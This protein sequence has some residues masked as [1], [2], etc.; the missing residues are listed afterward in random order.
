VAAA[1]PRDRT[2]D[3]LGA[4]LARAV[5]ARASRG[6]GTAGPSRAL[7]QRANDKFAVRFTRDALAKEADAV[8]ATLGEI[9]RAQ[10]QVKTQARA[11]L[12]VDH[13]AGVANLE[14]R[15]E[16]LAKLA[17]P[18]VSSA[19]NTR[20]LTAA[21]M[22]INEPKAPTAVFPWH[23]EPATVAAAACTALVPR[24]KEAI[25]A[26]DA[27]SE[28][29]DE[30]ASDIT[31]RLTALTAL[32]DG[33]EIA[34]K[35]SIIV[36]K[37]A[38]QSGVD[39]PPRKVSA[40]TAS[41]RFNTALG[42]AI[43]R[44][45]SSSFVLA[46]ELGAF[47]PSEQAYVE[48]KIKA[49]GQKKAAPP[50][51]AHP[52][53]HLDAAAETQAKDILAHVA[54]SLDTAAGLLKRVTA[55]AGDVHTTTTEHARHYLADPLVAAYEKGF[56][57]TGMDLPKLKAA[58]S[59]AAERAGFTLAF[60]KRAGN[61]EIFITSESAGKAVVGELYEEDERFVRAAASST[62]TTPG[63]V[64]LHIESGGEYVRD[65]SDLFVRRFVSR[66]LN[67]YDNPPTN[68]DTIKISVD[69]RERK[70]SGTKWAAVA[71][72]LPTA[73]ETQ[74]DVEVWKHQRQK[75]LQGGSP[76]V[77]FTTTKHAIFGSTAKYFEDP[78][79]GVAT[80][81]LAHVPKANIIDT[82]QRRAYARITGRDTPDPDMPFREN[83]DVVERNT[84]VR[85]AMRTRELVV[86]GSVPSTAIVGFD[87]YEWDS[88]SS[89][90]RKKKTYTGTSA[91]DAVKFI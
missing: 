29:A 59:E 89:T 17:L 15:Q 85:D 26:K 50:L 90:L 45:R 33:D 6:A 52:Y 49:V 10:R 23:G 75:E 88:V 42:A 61:T 9:Y 37:T 13:R 20:L 79:Y 73:P 77:S 35:T 60:E 36:S 84:A 47:Q 86:I 31:Q 4:I 53:A 40:T 27:L 72:T 19:L 11:Q 46:D 41:Q 56:L 3:A 39:V 67:E 28:L 81:D 12:D 14:K 76:F 38:K 43:G 66:C 22:K 34:A 82:H 21:S 65:A 1:P 51:P 57:A 18:L 69:P 58:W 48:A 91:G 7:L 71:T 5:A 24:A 83:D 16:E 87:R 78:K 70:E 80:I 54:S 63:E 30:T 62:S 55:I 32:A 74:R 68:P 64:Y 8:R 44:A 2:R 25:A